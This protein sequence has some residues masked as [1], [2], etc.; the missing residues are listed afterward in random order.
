MTMR[1]QSTLGFAALASAALLLS[2]SPGYS[3]T[4]PA[5]VPLPACT[6]TADC[7]VVGKVTSIEDKPVMAPP[8]PGSTVNIEYRIAV[9]KIDENLHGATGLT[10]IRIAFQ[11]PPPAPKVVKAPMGGIAIS[12]GPRPIPMMPFAVDIEGC[13]LLKKQGDETFYRLVDRS[14]NDYLART[15]R[16]FDAK[17]SLVK[18]SL[19][20]LVD[21]DAGLKSKDS[22][23]KI[24]TAYLLIT[25]YNAAAGPKAK[26]EPVDAAQ[27]KL[28]LEAI[29]NVDW[30]KAN[31]PGDP[32]TPSGV[33]NLL[34]L[35]PK[36]GWNAPKQGPN[37]DVRVF[38][39]QWETAAQKWVKDNVTTYRIQRWVAEKP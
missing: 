3:N 10:H 24:L 33:F 29:G 15:D 26:S 20:F 9:V 14:Y 25:R 16:E 32:V 8:F 34:R 1:R 18:R 22:A 30:S 2:A 39:K 27:S 37:Q 13:F 23:D 7:I 31:A 6:A 38:M 4:M 21:P 11:P 28:I 5:K 36:D 19:K 17:L 35:T 12:G